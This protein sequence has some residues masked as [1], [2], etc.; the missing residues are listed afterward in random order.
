MLKQ[1]PEPDLTSKLY[2]IIKPFMRVARMVKKGTSMR[3]MEPMADLQGVLNATQTPLRKRFAPLPS[4]DDVVPLDERHHA[5]TISNAS[6]SASSGACN[7]RRRAR[8]SRWKK[9][10]SVPMPY[11]SLPSARAPHHPW[12]SGG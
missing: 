8:S 4:D 2:I 7:L 11:I 10:R 12:S 9:A 5:L 3:K 1:R 6:K